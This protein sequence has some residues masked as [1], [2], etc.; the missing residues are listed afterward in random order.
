[1]A[2]DTKGAGTESHGT[3]KKKGRT[4]QAVGRRQLESNAAVC[5]VPNAQRA[6]EVPLSALPYQSGCSN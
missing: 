2:E 5:S 3:F 1:M 6:V 4:G